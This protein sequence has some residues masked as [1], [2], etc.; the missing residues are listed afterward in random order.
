MK[1]RFFIPRPSLA[2]LTAG[3]SAAGILSLAPLGQ[4][5]PD[6]AETGGAKYEGKAAKSHD[7]YHKS[8]PAIEALRDK[9]DPNEAMDEPLAGETLRGTPVTPRTPECF[10]A[11]PRDVFWQMD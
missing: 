3:I 6:H 11:E 9:A 8:W 2:F 10:P 7:Q 5:H 1:A 4:A